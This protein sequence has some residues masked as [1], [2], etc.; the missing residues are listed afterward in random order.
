MFAH[1]GL[2]PCR[3]PCAKGEILAGGRQG[4]AYL[5]FGREAMTPYNGGLG[6]LHLAGSW[7]K[8]L[9]RGQGAKP[10]K[11]KHF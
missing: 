2:K 9:A 10:L 7:T 6:A 3:R 8:P 5:G 1:S 4:V 11:L